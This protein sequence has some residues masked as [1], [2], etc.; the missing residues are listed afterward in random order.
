MLV[1]SGLLFSTAALADPQ[2][3]LRVTADGTNLTCPEASACFDVSSEKNITHIFVDW[4]FDGCEQ[5]DQDP[6]FA[7][8]VDGVDI[9]SDK[10]HTRGGPCNHGED[11]IPRTIWFPLPKNQDTA[12]VCVTV[13]GAVPSEILVGAKSA[14]ECTFDDVEGECQICEQQPPCPGPWGE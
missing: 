7:V 12:R 9:P 8:T 3:N 6:T 10:W 1:A 2:T 4:S 13:T 14:E 11:F 5:D